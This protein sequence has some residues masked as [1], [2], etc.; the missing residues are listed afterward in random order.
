VA[1]YDLGTVKTS[2]STDGNLLTF[3]LNQVKLHY[4][5]PAQEGRQGNNTLIF[6]DR[7]TGVKYVA[8]INVRAEFSEAFEES[9]F[10]PQ[11][12]KDMQNSINENLGRKDKGEDLT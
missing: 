12:A 1:I 10:I 11:E 5:Y 3:W 7:E 2:S 6:I 8:S 4:Y 9:F